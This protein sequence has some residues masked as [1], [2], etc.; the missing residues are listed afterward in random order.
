MADKQCQTSIEQ[1]KNNCEKLKHNQHI[2]NLWLKNLNNHKD[3]L[4]HAIKRTYMSQ[5]ISF[6]PIEIVSFRSGMF[7]CQHL[8]RRI[9]ANV[10]KSTLP[11][12][13]STAP[14]DL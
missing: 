7:D 13:H 1:E 4:C 10:D 6:D 9:I 12:S 3:T 11:I 14:N 2:I 5:S 8:S